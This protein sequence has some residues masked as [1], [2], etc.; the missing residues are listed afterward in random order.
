MMLLRRNR[1]YKSSAIF[2]WS[3]CY[4]PMWRVADVTSRVTKLKEQTKYTIHSV[5]WSW[6]AQDIH[7]KMMA[8]QFA[9]YPK[10]SC[11]TIAWYF[12][13]GYLCRSWVGMREG[14]RKKTIHRSNWFGVRRAGK[15]MMNKSVGRQSI[16]RQTGTLNCLYIDPSRR[17]SGGS[18]LKHWSC[19]KIKMIL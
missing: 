11:V 3:V 7:Q 18:P 15:G 14:I 17:R 2:V 4:P 1:R 16:R 8:V 12:P 10:R 6:T 19:P 13:G 5:A 9:A